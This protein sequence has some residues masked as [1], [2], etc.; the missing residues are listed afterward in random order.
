M[1]LGCFEILDTD[2][3]GRI[4]RL[5]TRHGTIETPTLAPVI[6]PAFNIVPPSEVADVGFNLLMTNAYIIWRR[7]GEAGPELGVHNILGVETPVMTDS[8]AYQLMIYG[9]VQV[10]PREIVEY[11]VKLGSDIGVILDIPTRYGVSRDT[12]KREVEETIRRAREAIGV[13]RGDMLLVGPVQG[14]TYLDIVAGAAREMGSMPFDIYAVGGPVQIMENY[15]YRQL[16]KLVMTAKMNLPEQRPLHLFGAGNPMM[17]ALA[18]AMGVDMFDS[19]SYALYA[20]DL[21]YMTPDAVYRLDDMVDL[22]CCCPVCSRTSV[23]EL[24]E[25]PRNERVYRIALHNLH[26]LRSELR[27]IKTSIGEGTLWELIER[28]ARSHPKL[29][30]AL[31]E[32]G[33]YIAYV[34]KFHRV[35]KGAVT[36][37]FFFDKYSRLRPEVYRYMTRYRERFMPGDSRIIVLFT[38]TRVKPFSRHGWI[39]QV[40]ERLDKEGLTGL[41]FTGVITCE[42]GL[43]PIGLDEAYPLAQYESSMDPLDAQVQRETAADVVWAIRSKFEPGTP[44]II[45]FE[46]NFGRVIQGIAE[47]LR[48]LGF[49]V[50]S[51]VFT[52]DVEGTVD[53]IRR[54]LALGNPEGRGARRPD[55]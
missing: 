34:E 23:E 17:M 1:S 12:V 52:G 35:T 47:K 28:R 30:E 33:R 55:Q 14:G 11:Q 13:E 37:V 3:L 16:V 40:V 31:A 20:R 48:R 42:Y 27:R 29:M 49:P 5:K 8:G 41:C 32:Y 44:V 54:V 50:Y 46:P 45:V 7:Y 25:L 2:L 19:A 6:N 4:G 39:S 21:R 10:T 36:G 51:R 18:V 22:P 9:E 43:V 26:V 24:K 15:E 38:E 53:Y